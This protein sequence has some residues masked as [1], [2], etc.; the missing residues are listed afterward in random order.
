[1]SGFKM[2]DEEVDTGTY[3]VRRLLETQFPQWAHL[4]LEAVSSTGTVNAIYKLG[5]EMAV[6]LPRVQWWAGDLD[7]ELACLPKLAGALPLSIPEPLGSGTPAEGYPFRWAIYRWLPG[8]PW[9]AEQIG[10]LGQAA[11]DLARFVAALQRVDTTGAP[12]SRR[13]GSV[14]SQD[15]G[16][17]SAI[18]ALAGTLDADLAT[19][20]WEASLRAP[21]WD[22]P[23][24]WMHGD[25]LPANLLVADGRLSAVID[26]GLAGV[27]DPAADLIAT[28]CL[29]SAEERS[30]YHAQLQVD[31]ATWVRG[32]GWALSIALQIIPYYSE[33][34]PG[35]VDIAKRMVDEV[36]GDYDN[37]AR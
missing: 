9:A 25:L 16:T 20:T 3:V 30:I 29:F 19:A 26:F 34:N 18:Q 1:M 14:V 8:E 7:T 35:F 21:A 28:W 36:L 23:A 2:H 22:R 33:T 4:R 27:G 10:D 17:R 5:R 6:R 24:V 13:G 32:R 31:D 15:A 37:L 11:A 12:D